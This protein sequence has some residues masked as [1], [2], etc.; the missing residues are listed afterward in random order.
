MA[1]CQTC[2]TTLSGSWN[3]TNSSE[4]YDRIGRYLGIA[5]GY[6]LYTEHPNW[7]YCYCKA[8]WQNEILKLSFVPK[9]EQHNTCQQQ[10][11]TLQ[12]QLDTARAESTSYKKQLDEMTE[13][14]QIL[15]NA[16][17]I[18][19]LRDLFKQLT[20][21]QIDALHTHT[22]FRVDTFE[23][24]H[25]EQQIQCS[26]QFVQSSL[27]QLKSSVD[28]VIQLQKNTLEQRKHAKESVIQTLTTAGVPKTL[29][30]VSTKP[31]RTDIEQIEAD[32]DGWNTFSAVL[33]HAVNQSNSDN[34]VCPATE[35]QVHEKVISSCQ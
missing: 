12:Q 1:E 10:L 34:T 33:V 9:I 19:K 3:M 30:D 32:I 15:S 23:T 20:T 17:G 7:V 11:E 24:V 31:L 6:F 4:H 27:T 25:A 29:I 2:K 13:K 21:P 28:A 26:S 35:K 14:F 16:S 8:C 18:E 22:N 5:D